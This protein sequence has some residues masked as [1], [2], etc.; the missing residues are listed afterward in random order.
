M[1]IQGLH[2]SIGRRWIAYLVWTIL[3]LAAGAQIVYAADKA[4]ATDP[5]T[6]TPH[7]ARYELKL[8][9]TQPGSP[10]INGF[11]SYELSWAK[12]CDGW[13]YE[14]KLDLFF[15][16]ADGSEDHWQA[17]HAAFESLDGQRYK[18]R[19]LRRLN[20]DPQDS[21]AGEATLGKDMGGQVQFSD[22]RAV[23]VAL[24]KGILFPKAHLTQLLHAMAEHKQ[25]FE[26]QV[27]DGDFDHPVGTV[28]AFIGRTFESP[29]TVPEL[30]K[31][32]TWLVR[33][34]YFGDGQPDAVDAKKLGNSQSAFDPLYEMEY[35]YNT[36]GVSH[37]LLIDF[38]EFSLSGNAS[39]IQPLPQPTCF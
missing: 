30:A 10:V 29:T 28:N 33:L 23:T 8:A 32:L 2:R 27:F 15:V 5:F 13:S 24:P 1:R 20:D 34:A 16:R 12:Q 18:F 11:G 7:R 9:K 39:D 38:G 35:S 22:P 25:L 21:Y 4:A 31:G 6:L 36:N 37:N 14:Q 26:R 17:S 19:T 3:W